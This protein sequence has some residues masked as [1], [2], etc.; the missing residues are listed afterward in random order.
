MNDDFFMK[1]LLR[2]KMLGV[3]IAIDDFGTGYSSLPTCGATLLTSSRSTK[4]LSMAWWAP[5]RA[6]RHHG[7]SCRPSP[8]F[9]RD[10]HR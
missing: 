10:C 5:I 2:L 8:C 6:G 4:D 3:A 7:R 1:V 9:R